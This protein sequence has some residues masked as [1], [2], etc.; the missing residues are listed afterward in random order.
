VIRYIYQLKN[1]KLFGL[2]IKLLF[3]TGMANAITLAIPF[4]ISYFFPVSG[5]TDNFF[6]SYSI[7]TF[8]AF[9]VA[10]SLK[11]VPVPFIKELAHDTKALSRFVSSLIYYC[12]VFVGGGLFLLLGVFII[13]FRLTGDPI[14][15]YLVF[16]LPVTFLIVKG[17]L[18]TGILNAHNQ[19]NLAEWSSVVR[20]LCILLSMIFL[21]RKFGIFSIII[22]YNIGEF[23]KTI[24]LYVILLRKTGITLAFRDVQ[25]QSIRSFLSHGSLQV[26][27]STLSASSPLVD[28]FVASYLFVGSVTLLDYGDRLSSVFAVLFNAVLVV[29]LSNWSA[30]VAIKQFSISRFK[31]ILLFVAASAFAIAIITIL[32]S[33]FLVDT[34]YFKL[35]DTDQSM[36]SHIL[37]I[38]MISF[39]FHALNQLV[40]RALLAFKETNWLFK[41]TVSRTALNLV[42]NAL[43][44]WHFGLIG[45]AYATCCINLGIFVLNYFMFLK[46]IKS[47]LQ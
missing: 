26:V 16:L 11:T 27:S 47:H 2:V 15:Q 45:I 21:H 22:G 19:Y 36:I 39:I 31:K 14:Y 18:F 17:A 7:I 33:D 9:T 5:D 30:E 6:L 12:L 46:R 8:L 20:A 40:N 4:F 43:F 32:F 37:K 13:A 34:L 44:A 42:F 25:L 23:L 1:N 41:I 3:V 28:R 35:K 38:S 29:V 24:Y 10:G